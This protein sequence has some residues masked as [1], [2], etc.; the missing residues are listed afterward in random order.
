MEA[1]TEMAARTNGSFWVFTFILVLLHLVLRLGL[2]VTVVPDLIV[3]AMLL[4]ARRLSG[5][6]AALLG[7]ILGVL[8]DS[9]AMVAFG[10]TA[11][12]FV[13]VGF[14]GAWS[15]N[16]FEGDSYLFTVVYVFLGAWL[17][18]GIRFA[19]GGATGRGQD[20]GLLLTVTPLTALL[21]AAAALVAL[22]AYRNFSG[23]R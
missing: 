20:P 2:G 5:A 12:A 23:N 6:G 7:L 8:A 18:E 19:A 16:F 11:V 21:T 9:L 22:I 13:I 17:V 10:A 1:L 3:V 4:A 14:L 15:R